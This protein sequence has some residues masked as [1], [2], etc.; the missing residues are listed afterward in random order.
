[1]ARRVGSDEISYA[2]YER[3]AEPLDEMVRRVLIVDLDSRLAP[4]MTLIEN[5][6]AS[7]ASL[8][9]SVDILR[10]DADATGLVKLDARWEMLGR[11]GG[12]IGAPHN[13][14]IVEPGSGRDAAAI[15][16]TMS[17]AVADLAGEIATG[18]GGTA[19][20]LAR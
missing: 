20:A 8:T 15:A 9:I 4:G 14:R 19:T 6:A 17:R 18:V 3:W 10:F 5:R 12:L 13:A 7:P 11:A 16:T 1:M 2:E